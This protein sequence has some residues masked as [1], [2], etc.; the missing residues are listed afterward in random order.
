MINLIPNMIA[1]NAAMNLLNH[2][3][4]RNSQYYESIKKEDK[5]LEQRRREEQEEIHREWER[6]QRLEER[7]NTLIEVAPVYT[8]DEKLQIEKMLEEWSAER[9]GKQVNN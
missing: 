2:Q 9:I 6:R 4:R 8:D 5:L 7:R 3:R 1:M